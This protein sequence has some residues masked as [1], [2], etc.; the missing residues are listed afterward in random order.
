MSTAGDPPRKKARRTSSLTTLSSQSVAETA[1]VGAEGEDIDKGPRNPNFNTWEDGTLSKSWAS[2]TADPVL[3][4]NRKGNAFWQKVTDLYCVQHSLT[5][6]SVSQNPHTRTLDQLK[7]RF[8]VIKKD[9]NEFKVHYSHIVSEAPSGVPQE[10]YIDLACDRFQAVHKRKFRFKQC[11]PTLQSVVC[12]SNE[13]ECPTLHEGLADNFGPV[14]LAPETVVARRREG[15]DVV[16]TPQNVGTVNMAGSVM[17]SHMVRPIGTK[18]AKAAARAG[19]PS[20]S[21]GEPTPPHFSAATLA[22]NKLTATLGKIFGR[23]KKK[24]TFKMKAKIW[25]TMVFHKKHAS[26]RKLA[27]E[28]WS[29]ELDDEEEEALEEEEQEGEEKVEDE[30]AEEGPSEDEY[31]AFDEDDAP[32]EGVDEV[33]VVRVV[34]GEHTSAN[35]STQDS[36]G[37]TTVVGFKHL[38]EDKRTEEE[39]EATSVN[40]LDDSSNS[41]GSQTLSPVPPKAPKQP[42]LPLYTNKPPYD[43]PLKS[44]R[45]KKKGDGPVLPM[46]AQLPVEDFG[47]VDT[48]LFKTQVLMESVSRFTDRSLPPPP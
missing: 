18:K 39:E 27:E 2:A 48:A 16:V 32:V 6:V 17:G 38:P 11:V 37:D 46:E 34:V 30:E 28:L 43:K 14:V 22:A 26:A 35:T 8:K 9:M 31:L 40:L 10:Q 47:S 33:E 13:K 1:T 29:Y 23:A 44:S 3:G 4:N 19:T 7:N 5:D 20:S 15:R 42:L 24:D 12:F 45:P 21:L 41:S 36:S 25:E